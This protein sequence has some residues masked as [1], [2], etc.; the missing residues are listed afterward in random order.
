MSDWQ[1]KRWKRGGSKAHPEEELGEV[2]VENRRLLDNPRLGGP[3]AVHVGDVDVLL[4]VN[5][6]LRDGPV[7]PAEVD[8]RRHLERRLEVADDRYWLGEDWLARSGALQK[9]TPYF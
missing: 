8:E 6:V 1:G 5:R 2:R 3:H 9:K 4:R 7:A